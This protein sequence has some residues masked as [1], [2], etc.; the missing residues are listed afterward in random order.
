METCLLVC[1]ACGTVARITKELKLHTG[2]PTFCPYCGAKAL[3]AIKSVFTIMTATIDAACF[4]GMPR[5]LLENL[6][7]TWSM[8]K[9]G[10]QTQHP[11]F[12]GYVRRR[13]ADAAKSP[14]KP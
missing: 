6:W 4:V 12:V 5:F 2:P 14:T 8:N 10:E 11:T 7:L 1:D 9:A 13:V 3:R